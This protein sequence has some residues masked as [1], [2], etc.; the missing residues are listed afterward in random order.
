MNKMNR[1][2]FNILILCF[3]NPLWRFAKSRMVEWPAVIKQ[4]HTATVDTNDEHL[5]SL[6]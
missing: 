5:P 2:V 1:T 6:K 3:R 4:L